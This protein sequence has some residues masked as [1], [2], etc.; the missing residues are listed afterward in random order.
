MKRL[1]VS[2]LTGKIYL[3]SVKPLGNG[4]FQSTGQKQD[5]TDEAIRSVYEMFL[6]KANE[7]KDGLFQIKYGDNSWMTMQVDKSLERSKGNGN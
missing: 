4:L 1:M 5:Y 7:S 3:T 6:Q 2:P